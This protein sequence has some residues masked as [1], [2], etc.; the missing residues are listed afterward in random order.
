M[1]IKGASKTASF[2]VS[3]IGWRKIY[4]RMTGLVG[5]KSTIGGNVKGE[6]FTIV[7]EGVQCVI[8]GEIEGAMGHE[9]G[10]DDEAGE[11]VFAAGAL[12]LAMGIGHGV[13]NLDKRRCIE[14]GDFAKS[15]VPGHAADI[16]TSVTV[17]RH[18]WEQQCTLTTSEIVLVHSSNVRRSLS[19]EVPTTQLLERR[20]NGAR[21]AHRYDV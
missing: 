13:A 1:A 4:R 6:A 2:F 14:E 19:P 18:A 9:E 12:G 3:R 17:Q 16:S 15:V 11:E 7:Q 20:H 8:E 10:N 21:W 5:G